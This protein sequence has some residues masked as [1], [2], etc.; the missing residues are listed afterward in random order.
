R[1]GHSH[2]EVLKDSSGYAVQAYKQTHELV[3]LLVGSEGTLGV[4]TSVEVALIP[5]PV[6][7]ASL[8]VSFRDLELAVRAAV[9]A[10]EHGA[11]ACELLDRTFLR[12][13]SAAG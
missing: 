3:D 5:A 6:G 13:A 8:F 4:F 2:A 1:A 12:I 11:S 9:A 10:R 7:T